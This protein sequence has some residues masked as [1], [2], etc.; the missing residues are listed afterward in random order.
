MIKKYIK[1]RF[2]SNDIL[3][4]NK[5]IEIRSKIIVVRAI[6]MKTTNIINKLS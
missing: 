4:L 6:F 2:N 3:L 1:I 5:P